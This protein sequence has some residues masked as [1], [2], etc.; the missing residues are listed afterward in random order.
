MWTA[1]TSCAFLR[2]QSDRNSGEALTRLQSSVWAGSICWWGLCQKQTDI[3]RFS[4]VGQPDAPVAECS[5]HA[6]RPSVFAFC[7]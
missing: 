5:V 7:S 2:G 3:H 1:R 4:A 6:S